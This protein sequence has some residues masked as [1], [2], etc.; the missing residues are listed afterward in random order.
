[1]R[2]SPSRLFR[3]ALDKY[4]SDGLVQLVRTAP[5]YLLARL[6]L[7]GR[8]VIGEDYFR[9]FVRLRHR[10]NCVRYQAPADPY[11]PIRV[12]PAN[13]DRIID[14]IRH[15]RGVGRIR[16][17]NWDTRDNCRLLENSILYR[18]LK[19]RFEE[20][21]DWEETIYYAEAER[22]IEDWGTM[23]G[24]DDITQFEDVRC[25]YV[26]ELYASIRDEGYRPNCELTDDFPE[27]DKR[28]TK[29]AWNDLEPLV[30]ISR[31]GELYLC[32]GRHRFTI[33]EILGIESIP[34]LVSVRHREWQKIRDTFA[35]IEDVSE[36]GS[37]HQTY[38]DHP[39]LQRIL[40]SKSNNGYTRATSFEEN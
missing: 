6:L 24:Y 4:R 15:E 21:R 32:D 9:S 8:L 22:I 30:A 13:I 3:R 39:D 17:G 1:M 18:G 25:R 33:A 31:T 38:K 20:N 19:Q 5:E 26:D 34:V 37:E 23:Y 35:A 11:E 29:W 10:F 2:G 14:G 40:S 7:R 16:G 12:N 27:C 36:V 28:N